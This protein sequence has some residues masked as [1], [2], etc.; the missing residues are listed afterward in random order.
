MRNIEIS[1]DIR[2]EFHD[3][4]FKKITLGKKDKTQEGLF[5]NKNIKKVT[6][7]L[8]KFG[9]KGVIRLLHYYDLDEE[10]LEEYHIHKQT[11]DEKT[12]REKERR[13]KEKTEQKNTVQD[14]TSV[15]TPEEKG[16]ETTTTEIVED[17]YMTPIVND[18]DY[19]NSVLYDPEDDPMDSSILNPSE[20]GWE[21][22]PYGGVPVGNVRRPI[23]YKSNKYE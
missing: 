11:L 20:A 9:K 10:I 16:F 18:E 6:T 5:P 2:E 8:K 4:P 3:V 22:H 1:F 21:N 7:I 23:Y 13:V 19:K 17:E 12:R 14:C 15:S